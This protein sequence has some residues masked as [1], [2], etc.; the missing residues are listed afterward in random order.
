MFQS[1]LCKPLR[2]TQ[3]I[4]AISAFSWLLNPVLAQSPVQQF[5][6]AYS[7]S[8]SSAYTYDKTPASPGTFSGCNSTVYRY[9]WKQGTENLLKL[10]SFTA[11]ASSFTVSGRADALV[12]IRR[13]NNSQVTGNRCIIYGET[14][15]ATAT[16]C[17]NPQQLNFKVPYNDDMSSFLNN[18]VINQGTDNLFT[19]SNNGDGNNN[20]IERLDVLFTA[21]L[22]TS[23]TNEVGFILCE[24]GNNNAHDGFRIAAITGVDLNNDPVSFGAVKTCFAGNGANN[25]SWGHPSQAN[26]N[27]Q[28]AAYVLRKD[29][30][31]PN[32]RVSSNVNQEIGAVYFSLADLGI[33][34]GQ[35]IYGYC[36][37][38]PDGTA[39]PSSAQILNLSNT[40]V[41]PTGTTEVQGGGLDLI[42][43]NTYFMTGQALAENTINGFSV[44]EQNGLVRLNWQI[45]APDEYQQL[46]V[47]R[48]VDGIH[49]GTVATMAPA[50]IQYTD[51]PDVRYIYYRLKLV[52]KNNQV[53]Y[54]PVQ[55]LA[56]KGLNHQPRL[57]PTVFTGET[58]L[59]A[60]HIPAGV[61]TVRLVQ[62]DGR[63][64]RQH[65]E[66]LIE[67]QATITARPDKNYKGV[68][69]IHLINNQNG[70]T[71][72]FRLLIH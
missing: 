62:P 58:S 46:A 15:L 68:L 33:A 2:A 18:N 25:G 27:R 69:F 50:C 52:T 7:R 30:A 17:V 66:H 67:N 35:R 6:M 28:I 16:C 5:S 32:L 22:V 45:N 40:S 63:L 44:Q 61:Y 65:T 11:N 19:N 37:L 47:E 13:V 36:L 9:N 41:Y 51:N 43:I 4:I 71:F 8:D 54:S 70:Q 38:G 34:P 1:I 21:G 14:T 23:Y 55:Q 48:S 26:G 72:C 53:I 60:E 12:R 20:N 31:E 42:A 57:Y 10:I 56:L 39:N 3:L 49:Y 64:V 59:I 24:R 29:E